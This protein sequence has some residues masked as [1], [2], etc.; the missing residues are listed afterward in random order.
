MEAVLAR[1][2]LIALLLVS[3]SLFGCANEPDTVEPGVQ[4]DV[5]E[6]DVVPG[7]TPSGGST[8]GMVAP[9]GMYDMMGGTVQALGILTYR[10]AEGGYWAV[11]NTAIPEEA[12]TAAVVVV[13]EPDDDIAGS[14]EMYRGQYVSVTGNREDR[15]H[16]GGPVMEGRTLEVVS[17]T[18][19]E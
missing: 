14:M 18:V 6:P 17:A 5:V 10:D 19:V 16:P 1:M 8:S 7:E 11:V 4:P 15:M 3:L 9:P 13:I 12:D 2:I